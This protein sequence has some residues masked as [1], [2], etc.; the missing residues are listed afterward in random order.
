L[1]GDCDDKNPAVNPAAAEVC[2]G[3]DNN[4]NG[5]IDEGVTK[6]KYYPDADKDG[7]GTDTGAID[8]C[9]SPGAGYSTQG[10]DCNDN[11]PAM[12]PGNPE[13]CDG[14]DNDCN[15]ATPDPGTAT[16]YLDSDGD[17]FGDLSKPTTACSIPAGYVTNSLDCND[18]NAAIN[19]NAIEVCDGVD[20]NCVGGIDEGPVET[21]P[22]ADGDT[23]G[24]SSAKSTFR[25]AAD[26]THVTNNKDCNDKNKA[27]NPD[28]TEIPGN[29]IDENCDGVDTAAGTVC[30]H[31]SYGITKL[32]WQLTSNSLLASENY[33][34][35]PAGTGYYWDDY[36]IS[37]TAGQTFT[38]LMNATD[39]KTLHPRM[40]LNENSCGPTNFSSNSGW[41]SFNPHNPYYHRARQIVKNSKSGYYY[42]ILTSY[43]AGQ[44]GGYTY[45]IIPGAL[46]Q[47]C[48]NK[49]SGIWPLGYR[50]TGS[51]DLTDV[52]LAGS[53]PV[54]TG[55]HADDF[56]FYLGAAQTYT[57]LYGG[58][59]Y[60]ERM[61]LAKEGDC[62]TALA[63]S[64]GGILNAGARLV[65][66]PTTAGIYAAYLSST[67]NASTGAY[68]FNVVPGNVGD[69]CFTG[70]GTG[71]GSG[72]GDSYVLYPL[73]GSYNQAL[74]IGDRVDNVFGSKFFDDYETWLEAGESVTFTMTTP[75][76]GF[77]PRMRLGSSSTGCTG[78]LAI[79]AATTGN[80]AT[81]TYTAPTAGIYVIVATSLGTS[82]TGNYSLASKYN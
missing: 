51:L 68:T 71:T 53:T 75:T 31:D 46:G 73:G 69:S 38:A 3:I 27:I 43:V 63:T 37:T 26:A 39:A 22:D 47:S 59:T 1:P 10:G 20:N 8:A 33:A 6:N 7:Y 23:F 61:L 32:P 18:A 36:E 44:T 52:E 12:F 49:D 76:G 4:C 45:Q 41:T 19:P 29:G 15:P 30:G 25:C 78:A 74:T 48:G 13:V 21:W 81:I 2:D 77:V 28:A 65:F 24:D 54:A 17:G 72:P 64:T 79:S 60:G 42:Q 50:Q 9:V 70:I 57:L 14:K 56:E 55:A 35:N 16:Y 62:A 82:Q 34:G 66:T 5:Q 58:M 11:D 80:V 40:Y 67:N